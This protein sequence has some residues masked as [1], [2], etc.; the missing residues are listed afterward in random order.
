[1]KVIVYNMLKFQNLNNKINR[2]RK[3][4]ISKYLLDSNKKKVF[5]YYLSC[6]KI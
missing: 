6:D 5:N 1:M 3:C 4:V 2:I